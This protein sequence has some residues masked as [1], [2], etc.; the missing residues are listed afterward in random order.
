MK[1]LLFAVCA[2]A[3]ISLLAPSAGFAFENRIGIYTTATADAAYI[4]PITASVPTNIYFVVINPLFPD[5]TPMTN[6]D[7]FEF[8]VTITGTPGTLFRL[9]ETMA[10]GA[11]NVGV[12]SDP[13]N[14]EYVVGL[15]TPL[16]VTSGKVSV[17]SWTV[18]PLTTGPYHFFLNPTTIPSVA[19][20]M[21][22]N[23]TTAGNATLVGCT[24]SSG[25]FASEVFTLGATNTPVV[26]DTFG[27]VKALFR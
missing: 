21:A 11:I 17:L 22:I 3:A 2:L 12:A 18:M 7:A 10:T 14:S 16:P 26:N 15:P 20:L 4:N 6:I 1:K 8:K 24:P 23:N 25:A 9:A 5:T 27:G 19:G 13:Y